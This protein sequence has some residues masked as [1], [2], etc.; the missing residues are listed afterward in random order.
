MKDDH[1]S[2]INFSELGVFGPICLLHMNIC[3]YGLWNTEKFQGRYHSSW[4]QHV[5][6]NISC[7]GKGQLL[8]KLTVQSFSGK[9][10]GR[11]MCGVAKVFLVRRILVYF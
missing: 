1:K 10:G 4:N 5:D 9:E 11:Q 8:K 6:S 3:H 7:L 2:S